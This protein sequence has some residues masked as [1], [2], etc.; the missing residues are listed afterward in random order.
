MLHIISIK[1][2]RIYLKYS[3]H[4]IL[5]QKV[6]NTVLIV[7]VLR[8]HRHIETE[9]AFLKKIPHLIDQNFL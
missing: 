8:F 2:T 7:G 1:I 5:T 4:K 6:Y 3:F 9:S